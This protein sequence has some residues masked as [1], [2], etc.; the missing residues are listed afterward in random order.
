MLANSQI[1]RGDKIRTYNYGQDRCTDHRSGL[2]VSNLPN[3]LIGG[4]VLDKVIA[5]A[6]AWLAERDIKALEADEEA[7][8]AAEQKK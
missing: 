6:Q 7:A 5:S 1:T 2:T 3:V 8:A 4:E